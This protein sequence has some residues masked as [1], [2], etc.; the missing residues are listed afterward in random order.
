[1]LLEDDS[2]F[3]VVCSVGFG[4]D[5]FKAYQKHVGRGVQCC[6]DGGLGLAIVP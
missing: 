3:L 4:R 2:N 5:N 6:I 1:M